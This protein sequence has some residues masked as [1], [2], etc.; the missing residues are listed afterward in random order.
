MVVWPICVKIGA[1]FGQGSLGANDIHVYRNIK[2][3]HMYMGY[4][5]VYGINIRV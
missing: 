1:G 2:D 5:L 3:V 4:I